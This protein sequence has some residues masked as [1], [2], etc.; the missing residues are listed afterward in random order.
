MPELM[1]AP[2]S[3][4]VIHNNESLELFLNKV[5]EFDRT[6]CEFMSKG[7]DFTVRLEVRGNR[8]EVIHV[9]LYADDLEKVEG[10]QGRIFRK[11]GDS[12]LQ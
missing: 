7:A 8:G 3:Q 2:C 4:K 10:C 12:V 11:N 6:F 1:Q 5:K 9:R